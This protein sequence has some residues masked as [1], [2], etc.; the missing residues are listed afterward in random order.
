[1]RPARGVVQSKFAGSWAQGCLAAASVLAYAAAAVPSNSLD[2]CI[3]RLLNSPNRING[4]QKGDFAV[5]TRNRSC[6]DHCSVRFITS[7]MILLTAAACGGGG[8]GG[9]AS[10]ISNSSQPQNGAPPPPP[11]STVSLTANPTSVTSGGSSTLIWSSTDATSCSASGGWSGAKGVSGSESVSGLTSTSIFSLACTG[12]GGTASASTTVTVTGA[13]SSTYATNF[14]LSEN[15]IFEGGAW[16]NGKTAGL[17]WN[18]VKTESGRAVGSVLLGASRYADNIAILSGSA[19][20]SN[21]YAQA[22]V[23]LAPGYS[24]P[25]NHEIEL[26]LRFSISANIAHGYEVLWGRAGY[27]A[28]VRWN[29][30]LGD[31]TPLYENLSFPVP[32]DGDV[33]KA[34]ISGNNITVYRNGSSVVTVDI[35]VAGGTIYSTGQPGIGFWPVDGATPE[36]YGWKTFEAGNM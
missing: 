9:G 24:P 19:V 36:N 23:Y 5:L 10:N 34:Q 4:N 29:G 15:P 20:A 33:L 31:Y 25:G 3:V 32:I 13:S 14:A 1:M 18:N 12:T 27:M 28:I 2:C 7:L 21:Q 16:I 22:T 11:V 8:G 35:G 26:L 6:L 30:P 17:D